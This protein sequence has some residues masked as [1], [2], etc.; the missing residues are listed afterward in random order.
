MVDEPVALALTRYGHLTCHD[1]IAKPLISLIVQCGMV[2][3]SGVALFHV[4]HLSRPARTW[5]CADVRALARADKASPSPA[6]V[7][8]R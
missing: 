2:A 3:L 6:F 8:F 4:K 1:R 7:L 5:L